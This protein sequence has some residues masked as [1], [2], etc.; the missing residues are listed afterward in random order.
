MASGWEELKQLLRDNGLAELADVLT[1]AIQNFGVENDALVY[2]EIRKTPVYQQRFKGSFDRLAAGKSF[3]DE[4]TYLQQERMYEE[5]LKAYQAGDL[6]SKENFARF[7]ANDVSPNELSN[8]FDAAYV[9]VTNAVNS[10]DKALVDE[11]KKMY[12]GVTNAELA[13]TLL[14]GNEG[15]QYLKNKIN[16]AEVKAAETEAGMQSS[17]GAEFLT[18]QGISRGQA[19]AGLSKVAEQK[20]GFEQASRA[21]GET[22]VEG[23]QGELE[24]ES[25]LG[26]TS[27]RT[28]RLASQARAEFGGQSAIKAGSLGRKAQV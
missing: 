20:T 7:I 11:L 6:A 18:S 1:A 25:L 26:Q 13:K 5:T 27:K 4:G 23:L 8:R 17:L 28:K 22:S 14:L 9:R 21:F 19:R 15:S 3:I 16:I 10:N 24:R 2:Q 12:P